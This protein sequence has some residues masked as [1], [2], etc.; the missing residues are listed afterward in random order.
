MFPANHHAGA[1]IHATIDGSTSVPPAAMRASP[2]GNRCCGSSASAYVRVPPWTA[3]RGVRVLGAFADLGRRM[4]LAGEGE[5]HRGTWLPGRARAGTTA[6][7]R[8][9]QARTTG[10]GRR[11]RAVS[12][13]FRSLRCP[14]TTPLFRPLVPE[15]SRM[16]PPCSRRAPVAGERVRYRGASRWHDAFCF[17]RW[18]SGIDDDDCSVLAHLCRREVLGCA[19]PW[20][21]RWSM[22]AFVCGCEKW[23]EERDKLYSLVLL[24]VLLLK[25]VPIDGHSL[26]CGGHHLPC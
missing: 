24:L 1:K 11:C 23:I 15:E 10:E 4:E 7:I 6:E 20:P 17:G 3:N 2:L 22:A 5:M 14:G 19:A 12:G 21:A 26:T 25:I 13:I 18:S 8:A 16:P 9:V